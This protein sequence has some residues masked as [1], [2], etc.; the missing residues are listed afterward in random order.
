MFQSRLPSF[1]ITAR[2]NFDPAGLSQFLLRAGRYSALLE[3]LGMRN[4][5]DQGPHIPDVA[6]VSDNLYT[7]K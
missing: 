4:Y 1:G 5:Q 6:I 2:R 7:F 3:A